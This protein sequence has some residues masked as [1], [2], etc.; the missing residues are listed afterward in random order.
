[1]AYS[2]RSSDSMTWHC[3][4]YVS[5]KVKRHL[6]NDTTQ[7]MKEQHALGNRCL[8]GSEIFHRIW[9]MPLMRNE[10]E[11][12][13]RMLAQNVNGPAI[14]N[15][16]QHPCTS[17]LVPGCPHLSVRLDGLSD[18]REW[19]KGA[20]GVDNLQLPISVRKPRPFA[21]QHLITTTHAFLLL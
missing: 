12:H 13:P 5:Q 15:K 19:A 20:H 10:I 9:T 4:K 1:M 11:W 6:T 16:C 21:T 17:L 8:E 3:A 2:S 14:R 7:E 18:G